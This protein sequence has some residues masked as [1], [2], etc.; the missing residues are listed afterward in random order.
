[1]INTR[2]YVNKLARNC[3]RPHIKVSIISSKKPPFK[4][5]KKY[6][7]YTEMVD[8]IFLELTNDMMSQLQSCAYD[9]PDEYVCIS[10]LSS[11]GHEVIHVIHEPEIENTQ[12][13]GSS[14]LTAPKTHQ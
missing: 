8:N 3:V 10:I 5:R 12:T 14:S 9:Y 13:Y 1:M 6:A 2:L 7:S 4:E 11:N